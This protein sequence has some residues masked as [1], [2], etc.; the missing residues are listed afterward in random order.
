VAFPLLPD[1][2]IGQ[3]VSLGEVDLALHSRFSVGH[4]NYPCLGTVAA[5]FTREAVQGPVL[6]GA[7]LSGL[8]S[9]DLDQGQA[10]VAHPM[11]DRQIPA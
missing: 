9:M 7:T 11:A 1:F 2:R 8:L 5:A 4:L 10:F 3:L 6:R